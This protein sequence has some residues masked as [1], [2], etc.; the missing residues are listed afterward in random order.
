MQL[1]DSTVDRSFRFG[2]G[3]TASTSRK[4]WIAKCQRAEDIGYDV[5]G[6]GDHIGMP[7]PF[8]A[9]M[10]AAE[11]TQ[12][13]RLAT[14]VVNASFHNPA[15]LAR[16][17]ATTDQFTDGRLELG[18]GAGYM[19]SEFDTAG[20]R[21]PG[22]GERVD[23][24]KQTVVELRRLFADPTHRPQPSQKHGPPLWLVGRGDRLLAT[25][26]QQADIIG[27]SGFT[28]GSEGRTGDL[29]TIEE[30]SERVEFLRGCLGER[31]SDVEFNILVWRVVV[32]QRRRSEAMRLEP[33][34]GLSADQMLCV[35]TVLIGTAPQISDQLIEYREVFGF[36]Y[37]TVGEYNMEAMAPVIVKLR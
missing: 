6:V 35:P 8:P 31:I 25:A 23:R 12:R 34:R 24:V 14:T 11:F 37:I 2:V 19:K 28:S 13:P 16:D 18:I 17:A 1:K 32:T 10:L 29:A 7:S 3:L 9:L 4:E 20:F 33:M 22:P 21:W 36:S 26:A 30:I 15:L 5:I 27:L